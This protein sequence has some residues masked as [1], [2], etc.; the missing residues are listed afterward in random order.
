MKKQHATN[1]STFVLAAKE[2]TVTVPAT[3]AIIAVHFPVSI[4]VVLIVSSASKEMDRLSHFATI[5]MRKDVCLS[6]LTVNPPGK[7]VVVGVLQ[8]AKCVGN[9]NALSTLR[10]VGKAIV[11]PKRTEKQSSVELLR[12]WRNM[13]RVTLVNN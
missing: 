2:F 12:M 1:V 7:M 6:V 3:T 10:I 11:Q 13:E 8:N 9:G 5:A 4:L